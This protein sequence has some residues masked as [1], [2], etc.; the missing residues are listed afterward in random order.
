MPEVCSSGS[1]IDQGELSDRE[2]PF[3]ED[4]L[5]SDFARRHVTTVITKCRLSLQIDPLAAT[6]TRQE[7]L[8][9]SKRIRNPR[10]FS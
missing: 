5:E 8:F 2:L 1:R 9:H 7:P 3:V 10:S 6:P 4:H